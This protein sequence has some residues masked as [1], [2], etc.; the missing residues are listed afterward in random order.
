MP[1]Q[2]LF[3]LLF[4]TAQNCVPQQA[5]NRMFV[6]WHDF[7]MLG[8]DHTAHAARF[9]VWLIQRTQAT[10]LQI[11]GQNLL[12][13]DLTLAIWLLLMSPV[14]DSCFSSCT[15]LCSLVT[16][17]SIM[18]RS[19]CLTTSWWKKGTASLRKQRRASDTSLLD[20]YS[21]KRSHA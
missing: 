15:R 9:L 19:A 16:S 12:Q 1:G 4:A 5:G 11:R 7:A 8:L 21:C 20:R 18:R 17:V 2:I 13:F 3:I 10:F 6:L 14:L